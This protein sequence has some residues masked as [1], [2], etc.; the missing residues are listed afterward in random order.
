MFREGSDEVGDAL[1][2]SDGRAWS[3]SQENKEHMSVDRRHSL[4]TEDV[5][6]TITTKDIYP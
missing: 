3:Q 1:L 5:F 2:G 4:T 6:P